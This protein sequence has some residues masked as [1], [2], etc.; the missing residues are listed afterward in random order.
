MFFTWSLAEAWSWL[1]N[2]PCL[3]ALVL[4]LPQSRSSFAT[5][6]GSPQ[7]PRLRPGCVRMLLP[8]SS[9]GFC[10]REIIGH[11]LDER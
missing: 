8:Q 7:H 2:L 4:C 6:N 9:T 11:R 1:V 10:R 3:G 5:G